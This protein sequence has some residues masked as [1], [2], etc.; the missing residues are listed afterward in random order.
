MILDFI[1]TRR[2]PDYRSELHRY[3]VFNSRAA[4]LMTILLVIS[5]LALDHIFYPAFVPE[6]LGLRLAA[7]LL[8]GLVLWSYRYD[9]GRAHI[10]LLTYFWLCVPQAMVSWMIYR[11]DGERSIYFVGLTFVLS[12]MA[13]FLPISFIEACLFGALTLLAYGTACA[14]H[15]GGI[16][17]FHAFWGNTIFMTFYALI[18]VVLAV[19]NERWRWLS[20]RLKKEIQEKNAALLQTNQ[21]LGEIK[22][23]MMQQEKMAALGTLAAGLLHEVNNPVNF[24]MMA[25]DVAMEEPA[26]R[27]NALISECLTDARQG[28]LR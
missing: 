22:G 17:D 26:A 19:Y 3:L 1:H 21:A 14:W 15:A 4:C 7:C 25:I 24:C 5:G 27:Q 20:F 16:Q 11:V 6:F 13:F 9:W 8:I 2:D 18:G 12:G 10:K 23:H 28:M